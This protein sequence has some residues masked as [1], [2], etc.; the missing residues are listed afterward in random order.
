MFSE[1][2]FMLAYIYI[3]SKSGDYSTKAPNFRKGVEMPP[4]STMVPEESWYG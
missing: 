4:P 1:S 2:S 3:P